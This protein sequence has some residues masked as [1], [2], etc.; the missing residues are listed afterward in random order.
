M[1]SKRVN[2][3]GNHQTTY[4][5][6]GKTVLQSYDHN[7]LKYAIDTDSGV[8]QVYVEDDLVALFNFMDGT[9]W[10]EV[11]DAPDD[12]QTKDIPQFTEFDVDIWMYK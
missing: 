5:D 2:F 11:T 9:G 12:C 1:A 6:W 4:S 8:I 10:V 3:P 7:A